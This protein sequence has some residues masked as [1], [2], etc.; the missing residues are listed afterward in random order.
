[1][2]PKCWG[3]FLS[4]ALW[5]Y[6]P[7]YH[8]WSVF[9]LIDGT[10]LWYSYWGWKSVVVAY[11]WCSLS[12]CCVVAERA[13][14]VHNSVPSNSLPTVWLWAVG[15]R[16]STRA[17]QWPPICPECTCLL[18]KAA[19][20]PPERKGMA[21]GLQRAVCELGVLAS[22]ALFSKHVFQAPVTKVS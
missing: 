10:P 18:Q 14:T 7:R 15:Q 19:L 8:T 13:C 2:G 9:V 3:S 6:L 17:A 5:Q 16:L 12:C 1:M 20:L 4:F 22:P 21:T 11:W